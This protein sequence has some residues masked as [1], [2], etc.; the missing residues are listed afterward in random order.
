[1]VTR[2]PTVYIPTF[3]RVDLLL[4]T[5]VSLHSQTTPADIVV[6]DNGST[7]NTALAVKTEF[8]DV[9]LLALPENTGFGPAINFGVRQRP[10]PLVLL[11]NNDVECHPQFVEAMVDALGAQT[12]AVAGVLL[13][14]DDPERIRLSGPPAARPCS[15]PTRSGTLA[16]LTTGS[17]RIWRTSTSPCEC[18]AGVE[19]AGWQRRREWC[20]I[21]RRHLAQARLARTS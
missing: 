18:A 4:R 19:P 11:L 12:D 10:S 17:L 2:R 8:P 15:V 21:T 7:D 5:L 1:M 13:Q 16:A 20:T 9:D 3:N 14:W 6:V